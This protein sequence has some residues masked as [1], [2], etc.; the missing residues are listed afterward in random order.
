M[1][2]VEERAPFE[3]IGGVQLGEQELVQLLPDAGS[4]PGAQPAPGR[5]P[6]ALAV[7]KDVVLRRRDVAMGDT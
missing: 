7:F 3:L 5:H 1:A 6:A 2:G 4:L